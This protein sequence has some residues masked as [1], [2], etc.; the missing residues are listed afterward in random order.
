MGQEDLIGQSTA[1]LFFEEYLIKDIMLIVSW[2][3]IDK[4]HCYCNSFMTSTSLRKSS[5][6][7]SPMFPMRKVSA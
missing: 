5:G 3:R 4:W 7:T 2:L 1:P 6:C